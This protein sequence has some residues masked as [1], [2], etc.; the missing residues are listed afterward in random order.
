MCSVECRRS[1][2][3]RHAP[4]IRI[5]FASSREWRANLKPGAHAMWD[6][7]QIQETRAA[8]QVRRMRRLIETLSGWCSSSYVSLLN[9]PICCDGIPV[10]H[11]QLLSHLPSS[12]A[13]NHPA[14]P[15]RTS[16]LTKRMIGN[17]RCKTLARVSDGRQSERNPQNLIK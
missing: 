6:L 8:T 1:Q 17:Q 5:R 10:R 3:V 11:L 13:R 9:N 4:R 12:A 14:A 16:A 7:A 15:E 2:G